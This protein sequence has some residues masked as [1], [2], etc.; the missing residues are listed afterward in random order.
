MIVHLLSLQSIQYKTIK[1]FIFNYSIPKE[2]EKIIII[3]KK[4]VKIILKKK[5]KKKKDNIKFH[6][7]NIKDK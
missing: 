3:H 7:N 1:K 5:K 4:D 2:E 6:S